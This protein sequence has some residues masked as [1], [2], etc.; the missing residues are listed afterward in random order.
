[1]FDNDSQIDYVND[2]DYGT[3]VSLDSSLGSQDGYS[4]S[5]WIVNDVLEESFVQSHTF[6]VNQEMDILSVFHS[7]GQSVALFRDTNGKVLDI[8]FITNGGN[9]TDPSITYPTKP[10]YVVSET[11][12][13]NLLTNITSDTVFTLQ[14]T[15]DTSS[16]FTLNVTNGS[17]DGTYLFNSTVSVTADAPASGYSFSH[18]EEDGQ[19]ISRN[20]TDS[21]AILSNRTI[22][23]IYTNGTVSDAPFI[24]LTEDVAV[25][26][27]YYSY[28]SRF[29]VP[30]DFDLIEWGMISNDEATFDI[31]TVGIGIHQGFIKIPDTNIFMMSFDK[32]NYNYVK[33]YLVLKDYEGDIITMY[34]DTRGAV[35]T[36]EP[37]EYYST[38]FEDASKGSYAIADVTLSGEVWSFNDAL[39]G[40]AT[41]DQ[42][43]DLKSV[44]LR[45]GD[46]TTK[47]TVTN[48]AE[49]NFL[50]GK[51]VN[52][53]ASYFSLEI[54]PDNATWTVLSN[55]IYADTNLVRYTFSLDSSVYSS[56][57]LDSQDSYY[58][59]IKSTTTQRVNIDDFHILTGSSSSSS[60]DLSGSEFQQTRPVN[61]TFPETVDLIY[62]VNDTFTA[63]TCYANDIVN[64]G[65]TCNASGTSTTVRGDHT[66]TYTATSYEGITYTET[67]EY[68][69]FRDASLLE[70]DYTGYYDGI[71]GLYGNDLLLKLREIINTGF[72]RVSYGDD[73]YYLEDI[74]ED[75]SNPGY[76]LLFY[77]H[78]YVAN[79]WD[80]GLTWNREHVWPNSRLGV[81]SVENTDVNI[82]SDLHNLRACNPS[83]NSSRSNKVYDTVT[84]DET[85]FPGNYS[86]GDASRILFYMLIAYEE[87]QLVNDILPNDPETNYTL[88]GAKMAIFDELIG[89][90]YDDPVDTFEQNRNNGI[91]TVQNNR[92][93]FIDYSYLV[94]LIWYDHANIPA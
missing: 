37:T 9:A 88:A 10:G 26:T 11:K 45:T 34:S 18:W 67:K 6:I 63:G 81:D 83:V 13:D 42:K 3:S 92:N 71:E 76:V 91:Y 46:I 86:K 12:W 77:T 35:A 43:V 75:Q 59:R 40:T 1:M 57:G 22:E 52:D 23:A 53:S 27:G 56:L 78:T 7:A 24:A 58:I 28:V 44:R 20:S 93:P 87:L 82:A 38:G 39:L 54:S 31:D 70:V 50:Y 33:A 69:V 41:E 5:Y 68:T 61:I 30:D 85:Y 80:E 14:Y 90:N 74:D 64:E 62:S 16:T 89:W 47:F 17:G 73:R 51:Y 94:E 21:F 66:V 48:L 8:Q 15:I 84:T 29:Y 32:N 60:A 79:V 49:I 65:A 25:R 36:S 2:V 55:T 19:V 72:T 4:F